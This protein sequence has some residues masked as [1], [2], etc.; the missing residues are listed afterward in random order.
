[1]G[2]RP[3]RPERS[4][5]ANSAT[6]APELHLAHGSMPADRRDSAITSPLADCVSGLGRWFFCLPDKLEPFRILTKATQLLSP[7][8][9]YRLPPAGL[10]PTITR[11]KRV[12]ISIS[13]RGQCK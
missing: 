12:V 5:Y 6:S 4:A 2:L 9:H 11:P 7:V 13:P 3:L 10:E 8:A 1:M